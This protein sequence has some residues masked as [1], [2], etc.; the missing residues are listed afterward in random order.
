MRLILILALFVS[1]IV[2]RN[3]GRGIDP[4]GGLRTIAPQHRCTIDPHGSDPC[5]TAT[6][7]GDRGAGLDPNG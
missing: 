7:N 1:T 4:N 3:D 5:A 6:L 2:I